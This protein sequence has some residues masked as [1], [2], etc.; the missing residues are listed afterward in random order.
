MG[1]IVL[2]WANPPTREVGTKL[3]DPSDL[4]KIAGGLYRIRDDDYK[5]VWKMEAG[6]DGRS[7]IVRMGDEDHPTERLCIAEDDAAKITSAWERDAEYQPKT[8]E[9]C[10]CKPGV[11]RDNCPNCEGTGSKIDFKKIR[12][13]NKKALSATKGCVRCDGTGKL[14]SPKTKSMSVD[15]PKCSGSGKHAATNKLAVDPFAEWD[16]QE[17]LGRQDAEQ[18]LEGLGPDVGKWEQ[19]VEITG[20]EALWFI[21]ELE[22]DSSRAPQVIE[23]LAQKYHRPGQHPVAETALHTDSDDE[24]RQGDYLLTWNYEGT[25]YVRL[26]FDASQPEDEVSVHAFHLNRNGAIHI[27][28]DCQE[29]KSPNIT[30]AGNEYQCD[31]CHRRYADVF[32]NEDA[33]ADQKSMFSREDIQRQYGREFYTQMVKEGITTLHRSLLDMWIREA[34]SDKQAGQLYFCKRCNTTR[35][36]LRDQEGDEI[37]KAMPTGHVVRYLSCGHGTDVNT[38]PSQ[39]TW[40]TQ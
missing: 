11:H 34:V 28:W 15:C 27:C 39:P 2:N 35:S 36:A 14:Y 38:A 4:K 23:S 17:E 33:E 5:T 24:I 9:P 26:Q 40:R 18:F 32:E 30:K 10:S 21:N 13:K 37:H 3:I 25:P 12:D 1:N 16:Q 19:V 8:G 20:D 29:C 6:E 31:R 7:Y 22:R